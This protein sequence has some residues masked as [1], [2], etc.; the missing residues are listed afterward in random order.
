VFVDPRVHR[1]IHVLR[2][3]LRHV[4]ADVG[5]HFASHFRTVLPS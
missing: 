5:C 4:V 1:T 3:S 2:I